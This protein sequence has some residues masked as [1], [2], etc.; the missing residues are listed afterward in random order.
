MCI[1][2]IEATLDPLE[3]LLKPIHAAVEDGDA[4][5]EI[6]HPDFQVGDILSDLPDTLVDASEID[7]NDAVR[8]AHRPYSAAMSTGSECGL[9]E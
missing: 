2:E 5:L 7:E 9:F 8:F 6:C 1:D 3:P 4:L